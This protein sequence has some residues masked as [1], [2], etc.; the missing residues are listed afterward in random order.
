MRYCGISVSDSSNNTLIVHIK[1][2]ISEHAVTLASN[3]KIDYPNGGFCLIVRL[4]YFLTSLFHCL[5]TFFIVS[6]TASFS[7]SVFG[8]LPRNCC[9]LH[10]HRLTAFLSF[11]LASCDWKRSEPY[12]PLKSTL[13][14]YPCMPYASL[15]L[16]NVASSV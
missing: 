14:S 5:I 13:E 3:K 15:P 7:S 11:L 1:L 4:N 10:H 9:S 16:F 2:S 12:W 8:Y 6:L